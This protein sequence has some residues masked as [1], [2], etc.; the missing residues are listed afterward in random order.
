[1]ETETKKTKTGLQAYFDA[2]KKLKIKADMSGSIA[3]EAVKQNGYALQYV[4]E[5]TFGNKEK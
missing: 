4:K 3:L 5:Q 2:W 1:M